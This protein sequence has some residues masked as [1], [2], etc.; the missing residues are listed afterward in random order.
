MSIISDASRRGRIE[1][2]Q[3]SQLHGSA[4]KKTLVA[5]EEQENRLIDPMR[6]ETI[7]CIYPHNRAVGTSCPLRRYTVARPQRGGSNAAFVL[8]S[9]HHLVRHLRLRDRKHAQPLTI[10]ETLM[11]DDMK[12]A[13]TACIAQG[14]LMRYRSGAQHMDADS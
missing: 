10:Q 8:V 14:A 1:H 5:G 2:R 13:T 11:S 6:L 3:H 7:P 12:S 9:D 4:E